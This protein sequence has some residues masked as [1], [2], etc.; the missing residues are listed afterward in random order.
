M[1][2]EHITKFNYESDCGCG[3]LVFEQWKDD[4]IAF[5]SYNIPAYYAYQQGFWDSVIRRAKIIWNI[6]LGR[7]YRFYEIVIEDNKTLLDF[8]RF[9]SEMV[10]VKENGT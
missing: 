7:E 1:K 2:Q 5:I 10:E 6:L 4:G 3:E 9:V 8:K